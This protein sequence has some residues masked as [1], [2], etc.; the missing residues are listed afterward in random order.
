MK[1]LPAFLRTDGRETRGY[2]VVKVLFVD[3]EVLAMEYLQNLIPWEEHGYQVVGHAR[4]GRRALDLFDKERP[5]IVISDIK[6]AGMD[7]LELT[8]KIKEKD[9]DAVIVLLSAYRDFE[10]AQKGIE[11]GV[12]N[13]LLKHELSEEKL[14]SELSKI[15]EKLEGRKQKNKI[16]HKYFVKQ[17]I[18]NT[19]DVPEDAGLGNRFFMMLLQKNDEFVHGYFRECSWTQEEQQLLGEVLQKTEEGIRYLAQEQLT[20]N[21]L[22]VLYCIE[23][24]NSKY[25]IDS[26]IELV[27]RRTAD[28]LFK[29]QDCQFNLLYSKEISREEISHTFQRMSGLIRYSVYWKRGVYALDAFPAS[30]WQTEERKVLWNGRLGELQKMFRERS[31]KTENILRDIFGEL[32]KTWSNLVS[33]RELLY[34][35]ESLFQ[36]MEKNEGMQEEASG[37]NI[38]KLSEIEEYY[39]NRLKKLTAFRTRLESEKYS[40][41]VREVLRYIHQHYSEEISLDTLGEEL[42]MNGVYLGQILKKETGNTFLKYLTN[43]RMEEAK[44]LLNDG[45]YN[46]SEVSQMVGYKTSQYFSQIF[47]KYMGMSPQEYRKWS[48]KS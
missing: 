16:Y 36:E 41:A 45:G 27:C 7:G 33:L 30:A 20:P 47:M 5:Q 24:M 23:D 2:V 39:V 22:L 34:G 11:Y 12:T 14:F 8:R 9:A 18:Y 32:T 40:R 21:H 29:V 28:E 1:N 43:Y 38:Y 15:A 10:Y 44:R 46:I 31:G 42:G 6:M 17:L 37:G 4:S 19:G 3:D 35:L 26:R 25:M 13:Y 48:G